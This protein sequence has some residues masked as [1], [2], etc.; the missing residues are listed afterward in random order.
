MSATKPSVRDTDTPGNVRAQRRGMMPTVLLLCAALVAAAFVVFRTTEPEGTPVAR[1]PLPER[2]ADSYSN[3]WGAARVQGA[4]EGTDL[5]A[6]R[7][8]PIRSIT[9][10]TVSRAWGSSG[11]GW[12]TLGGYTVMIEAAYDMG[13]I[14]R[15]DRLYYAHMDAPTELKP[16]DIV[17][18]G[19]KIGEVGDTG[20]GPE[21][22]RSN[23]EPHLHLGWYEGWSLL[24]AERS[25]VS[26]GAINPYPLLRWIRHGE[27][28]RPGPEAVQNEDGA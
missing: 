17:E 1:F 13:P 22:T 10:G 15:G 14:E 3:D 7:G 25:T 5:F 21:G 8:T 11:N 20:Q 24:S 26:S 6:P 18:A 27:N 12:N 2:Y 9:A 23:F 28:L 19:Q 16:G 4:H